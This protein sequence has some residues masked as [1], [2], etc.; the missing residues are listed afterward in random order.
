MTKPWDDATTVVEIPVEHCLELLAQRSI[1]RFAVATPG[2][3][4]LVLPVNYVMDHD[5]VVFRSDSG[6]KVDALRQ[7]PVSFEIDEIDPLH[8]TGWSVLVKGVA[9][10]ATHWEVE[11]LSIEPWAPGNKSRWVRIVPRT[12]TGRRLELGPYEPDARAYL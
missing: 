11:H 1:G 12:I 7:Q 5:V 6:E 4:P 3:A 8:H 10:E 2:S 9:Y